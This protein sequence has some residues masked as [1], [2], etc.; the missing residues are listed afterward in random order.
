MASLWCFNQ[1]SWCFNLQLLLNSNIRLNLVTLSRDRHSCE[2][3]FFFFL[4]A[5]WWKCIGLFFFWPPQ[6]LIE[7]CC[8]LL[9]FE[10]LFCVVFCGNL[11]CFVIQSMQPAWCLSM[12]KLLVLFFCTLQLSCLLQ[13]HRPTCSYNMFSFPIFLNVISIFSSD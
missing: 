9:C 6:Q 7:S 12:I 11:N 10:K 2:I 4:I 13:E 1:I 8:S 5:S 3:P